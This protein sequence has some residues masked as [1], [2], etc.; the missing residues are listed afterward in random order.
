MMALLALLLFAS[1]ADAAIKSFSG[2]IQLGG[3]SSTSLRTPEIVGANGGH[4][5]PQ[6]NSMDWWRYMGASSVRL[7]I[8][9]ADIEKSDD[10]APEGDGV[11]SIATFNARKA[12]LRAA[13]NSNFVPNSYINW[14]TFAAGYASCCWG[15]AYNN[16]FD[17]NYVLKT[18]TANN[19]TVLM[20]CTTKTTSGFFKLASS[21]D[22]AHMWEIWQHCAFLIFYFICLFRVF[23]LQ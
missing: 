19:V 13:P 7:F 3:L 10:I 2:A 4:F 17:L 18:F 5:S 16:N 15:G 14:N 21:T 12:A 20:Q 8:S 23:L 11:T 1:C 9:A 6:T 22:Y